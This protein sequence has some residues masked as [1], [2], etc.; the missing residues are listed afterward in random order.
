[1]A[2]KTTKKKTLNSKRKPDVIFTAVFEDGVLRPL[3]KVRLPKRKELTVIIRQ[4]KRSIADQLRGLFK[5]KDQKLADEI[6]ASE[7]WL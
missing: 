5:P 6:I 2:T 4:E 3:S 7:D 1:M